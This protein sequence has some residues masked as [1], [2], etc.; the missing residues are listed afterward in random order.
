MQS[1]IPAARY[2]IRTMSTISIAN[3]PR[4]SAKELSEL[5]LA[6][7]VSGTDQTLAVVDVRDDGELSRLWRN[8]E[9]GLC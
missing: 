5:L 9:N 2:G 3:L 1:F 7:Q 8:L 4:I 6:Q